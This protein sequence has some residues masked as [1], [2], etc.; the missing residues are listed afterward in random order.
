MNDTIPPAR[1]H[2]RKEVVDSVSGNDRLDQCQCKVHDKRESGEKPTRLT[3]FLLRERET[4]PGP[5]VG[6]PPLLNQSRPLAE[7]HPPIHHA[8]SIG[9]PGHIR[10]NHAQSSPRVGIL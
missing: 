4:P 7:H 1:P 8:R 10:R 3:M 5:L 2:H 9:K 6:P